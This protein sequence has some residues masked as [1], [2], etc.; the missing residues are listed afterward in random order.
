MP[1]RSVR[2]C[3]PARLWDIGTERFH[4]FFAEGGLLHNCLRTDRGAHPV[5]PAGYGFV[6]PHPGL[7]GGAVGQIPADLEVRIREALTFHPRISDVSDFAYAFTDDED[8]LSVG[9]TVALD[10]DTLIPITG[11][12]MRAVL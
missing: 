7:I 12:R 8:F 4:C 2:P 11:V 9:F 1:V 6:R 3:G 5:H 10:D